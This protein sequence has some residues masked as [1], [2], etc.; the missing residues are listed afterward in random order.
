MGNEAAIADTSDSL[1][2]LLRDRLAGLVA[3][4][5]VALASPA[6]VEVDTSPSLAVFL[7]HVG[8]NAHLRSV[9]PERID[10][11][12]FRPAPTA[13]DLMY[14][15]VPYAQKREDEQKILG[16]VI[17]ALAADPVLRGSWLQGS[18]AGTDEQIRIVLHR[19][20]LEEQSRLWSTF[21]NRPFKASVCYELTPI[22]IQ[23]SLPSA[24]GAPVVEREL[25]MHRA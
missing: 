21:G 5:H 12:T 8:L 15:L 14:M 20:T 19:L 25:R 13:L 18:L 1:L 4:D 16:Q 11:R 22:L 10:A 6:D 9:E 2:K 3:A 7:Y 23:S 17:Q 24:T